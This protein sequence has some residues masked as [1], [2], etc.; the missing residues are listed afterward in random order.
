M[1]HH[2]NYFEWLCPYNIKIVYSCIIIGHY[3]YK[4]LFWNKNHIIINNLWYNFRFMSYVCIQTHLLSGTFRYFPILFAYFFC[5]FR[6]LAY[7][8][9]LFFQ[10]FFLS[11]FYL[12]LSI[13]IKIQ[14]HK[15]KLKNFACGRP[16]YKLFIFNF[17]S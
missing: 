13:S 11:N 4:Y 14:F 10:I 12:Q 3:V 2:L 9:N 1:N 16:W 7:F 5:H 8:L 6:L 15:Q 17:Y